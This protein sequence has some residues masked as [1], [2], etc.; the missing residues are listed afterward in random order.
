VFFT[1]NLEEFAATMLKYYRKQESLSMDIKVPIS[2]LVNIPTKIVENILA[3]VSKKKSDINSMLIANS[4]KFSTDEVDFT[5]V[6][7]KL[8]LTEEKSKREMMYPELQKN[9]SVLHFLKLNEIE[10]KEFTTVLQ[11]LMN[12]YDILDLTSLL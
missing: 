6:M 8:I 9:A 10:A 7:R 11:I 5:S 12:D 4:L 2:S 3:L 1:D